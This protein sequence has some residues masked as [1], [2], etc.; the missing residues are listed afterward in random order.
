[1][2]LVFIHFQDVPSCA[3]CFCSY[4]VI[5]IDSVIPCIHSFSKHFY[6][7]DHRPKCLMP[8]HKNTFRF[9]LQITKHDF[10]TKKCNTKNLVPTSKHELNVVLK[11]MHL[12]LWHTGFSKMLYNWKL[13]TIITIWNKKTKKWESNRFYWCFVV[14]LFLFCQGK[15]V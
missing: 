8:L 10:W 1:M 6:A 7:T 3:F 12:I 13:I 5:T 14:F 9:S 4:F 2:S 15:Y 11:V